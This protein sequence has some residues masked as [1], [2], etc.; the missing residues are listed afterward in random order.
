MILGYNQC[1]DYRDALADGG[2]IKEA[3][4]ILLEAGVGVV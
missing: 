2:K 4:Q 1:G 3:F